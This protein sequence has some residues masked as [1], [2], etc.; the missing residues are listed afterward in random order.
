MVFGRGA[1]LHLHRG[2][3]FGPQIVAKL[4]QEH[5]TGYAAS[6]IS[7]A[8]ASPRREAVSWCNSASAD[9]SAKPARTP[10]SL[11]GP[12]EVK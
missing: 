5:V 8:I 3:R 4:I 11:D 2:R 1:R 6:G 7:V 10:P 12:Y 9:S